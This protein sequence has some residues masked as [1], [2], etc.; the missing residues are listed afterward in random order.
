MQSSWLPLGLIL[1]FTIGGIAH[2]AGPDLSA[3]KENYTTF[4]VKCH[5]ETGQGN[6]PAAASL[7]TK[8]RN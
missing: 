3:A 5:G 2:A 1:A 6:G 4:C 7:H 8:P